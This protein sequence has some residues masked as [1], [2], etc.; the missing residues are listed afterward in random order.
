[1]P[2]RIAACVLVA[3][4]ALPPVAADARSPLK[5][6][7]MKTIR[8]DARAKAIG[9]A[10]QYKARHWKLQCGK[11]TPYSAK[12]RIRLVDVRAGTSDCTI[13]LVYVVSGNDAI[14]GNLGR[15]GC[16]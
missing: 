5:P 3:G 2:R 14:Q 12:C 16:A 6:A 4:L 15:D 8:R 11:T 13:A 10:E 1:M 7:D 9:F